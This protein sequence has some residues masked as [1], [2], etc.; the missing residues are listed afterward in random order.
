M[1]HDLLSQSFPVI[2]IGAWLDVPKIELKLA[3]AKR[4]TFERFVVSLNFGE[5]YRCFHSSMING[6]KYLLCEFFSARILE[7]NAKNLESISETLNTNTDW[8][9]FHV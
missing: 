1:L 6:L 5:F 7:R 3:L 2:S 8:S 9:V 4:R